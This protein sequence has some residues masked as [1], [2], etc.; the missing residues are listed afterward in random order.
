MHPLQTNF[1][2]LQ[3][4]SQVGLKY[5]FQGDKKNLLPEQA[6]PFLTGQGIAIQSIQ[7]IESTIE[8]IVMR[9]FDSVDTE[10]SGVQND[11]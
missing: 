5:V 6:M 1:P 3:L 4:I 2:E 7:V 10:E 9:I 11:V 8:N